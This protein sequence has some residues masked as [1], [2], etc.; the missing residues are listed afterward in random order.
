MINCSYKPH[1]SNVSCHLNVITKTL[2]T[3]YGKYENVVFLGDFNA[4]N[5]E[6]TMK[7]FCESYNL[8]NLIKQTICFKNPKKPSCINLILTNRPKSFQTR[9]VI[10]TGLSDFHRLTV[11]ILKRTFKNF[12]LELLATRISP[13]I[14]MESL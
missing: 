7:S 8:T 14:I 11:S 9:C 2:D 1:K 6:T 4:E 13:I 10:E 3:Y 12:H 5:E